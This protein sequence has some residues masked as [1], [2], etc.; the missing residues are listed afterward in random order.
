MLIKITAGLTV[1][2]LL[3]AGCS[4]STESQEPVAPAMTS[5]D[6]S[7]SPSA[8]QTPSSAATPSPSA[9]T[10]PTTE[11]TSSPVVITGDD[12]LVGLPTNK[13]MSVIQ[14]ATFKESDNWVGGGD[15]GPQWVNTAPLSKKQRS[16]LLLGQ[17]RKVKPSECTLVAFVDGYG[18]TANLSNRDAIMAAAYSK[19]AN[20]VRYKSGYISSWVTTALVLAPGQAEVW[21]DDIGN[22]RMRCTK[23]TVIDRDGDIERVPLGEAFPKGKSV[24]RSGDAYIARVNL[25]VSQPYT[26]LTVVE[27]IGSIFYSTR[28]L[29]WTESTKQLARASKAYNK[30]ANNLAEVAGVEREAVDF[31]NLVPYKPDPSVYVEPVEPLS[32]GSRA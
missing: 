29:M 22:T 28:M 5:A 3:V 8:G 4:G 9:S 7:Q 25:D 21:A 19:R 15:A 6:S 31:N 14:G 26:W 24:F 20:D 23:Y 16:Q 30:L 17:A 10:T 12:L 2:A 11:P 27:P 18:L 13:Q 32:S 1:S